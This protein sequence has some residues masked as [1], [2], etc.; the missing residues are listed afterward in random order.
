MNN[1]Y[2]P[3]IIACNMISSEL[4]HG[5]LSAQNRHDMVKITT[6]F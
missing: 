3:G 2:F 6:G 5:L 1:V 4:E